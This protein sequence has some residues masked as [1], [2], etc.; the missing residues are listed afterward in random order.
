MK[1]CNLKK[2][3]LIYFDIVHLFGLQL[4]VEN[5]VFYSMVQISLGILISR[6]I[7]Q[8]MSIIFLNKAVT[9]ICITF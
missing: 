4:E 6:Y 2:S 8:C 9:M 5:Y 3:T 1:K 7:N